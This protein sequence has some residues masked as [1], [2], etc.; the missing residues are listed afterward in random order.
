MKR[1][2]TALAAS[3]FVLAACKTAPPDY[4][5]F[6][7]GL[8]PDTSARH[9]AERVGT[10]WFDGKHKA[11]AD[12]SYA[13]EAGVSSTRILIV[14]KEEPHGLPQLVIEIRNAKRGTDVRLFGPL[15]QT[16]E[17]DAIRRDVMRWTGG[18]RDC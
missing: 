6:H 8:D 3:A 12:Y 7:A 13:P 1:G 5:L 16:D 4:V 11:F 9:I 10:C 2:F 14:P 17:A 18:A 15:M